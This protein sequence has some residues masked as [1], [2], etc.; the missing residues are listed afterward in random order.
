MPR[1]NYS[2]GYEIIEQL[3]DEFISNSVATHS[4]E[5]SR[6][7]LSN[8]VHKVPKYRSLNELLSIAEG[9]AYKQL[10]NTNAQHRKRIAEIENAISLSPYIAGAHRRYVERR[11]QKHQNDPDFD[12]KALE[13]KY[14]QRWVLLSDCELKKKLQKFAR[15]PVVY[16]NIKFFEIINISSAQTL[17]QCL[18][19]FV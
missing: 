13:K 4:V 17:L 7:R 11:I 15:Y 2:K 12:Y 10:C 8:L 5:E 6:S 9:S 14:S 19:I 16:Y 3:P 1:G 18:L